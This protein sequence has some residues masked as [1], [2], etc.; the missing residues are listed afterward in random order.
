[1]KPNFCLS[2]TYFKSWDLLYFSKQE[3]VSFKESSISWNVRYV[4]FAY[5]LMSGT[6]PFIFTP[7]IIWFPYSSM[8]SNSIPVINK[9]GDNV[10][11]W[12]EPLSRLK[13]WDTLPTLRSIVKTSIIKKRDLAYTNI[14]RNKV[15]ILTITSSLKNKILYRVLQISTN[16]HRCLF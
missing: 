14:V 16:H 10:F 5:W 1:M 12:P 4:S 9:T 8:A 3:W 15:Q 6:L 7:F 11:P 2:C 13:N